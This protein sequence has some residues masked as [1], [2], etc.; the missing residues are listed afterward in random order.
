MYA[1]DI[2]LLASSISELRAM[3]D[4]VTAYA[5]RNRYGLNGAK[6]GVMVFNADSETVAAVAAQQW[7]LSGETVKVVSSYKYLGVDLLTNVKDWSHYINRVIATATRVSEDLEWACRRDRGL[8]SRSAV[9]LWK[10]I[11][12]PMLEYTAELW[13]GDIRWGLPHGRRQFKP[14]LHKPYVACPAAREFPTTSTDLNW[15]WKSSR[16]DGRS[17]G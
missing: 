4:V 9:T 5:H 6:S 1:D 13:A 17:S 16:P 12:R 10:A 15:A 7:R 11:V 3:N 8:R 14:T 2:V